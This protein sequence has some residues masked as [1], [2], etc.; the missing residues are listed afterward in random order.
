MTLL[1]TTLKKNGLLLKYQQGFRRNQSI[2]TNLVQSYDIVTKLIEEGK[3]VEVLCL[4]QA[5]AFDKVVC[6]FLTQAPCSWS[7]CRRCGVDK[8]VS[9]WPNPESHDLL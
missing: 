7:S 4:D 2:E 3:A 5:M 6:E 9:D 1:L 8:I